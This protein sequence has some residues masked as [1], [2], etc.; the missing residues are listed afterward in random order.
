MDKQNILFKHATI[1]TLSSESV[2]SSSS[3]G[4]ANWMSTCSLLHAVSLIPSENPPNIES[5]SPE[6]EMQK[7]IKMNSV[8][9]TKAFFL[10]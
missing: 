4:E 1:I 8:L 9:K 6:N 7:L 3:A 2:S 5:N 10:F